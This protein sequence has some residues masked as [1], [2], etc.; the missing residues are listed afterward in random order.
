ML[1]HAELLQRSIPLVKR[2]L[3]RISKFGLLALERCL[4][5][6]KAGFPPLIFSTD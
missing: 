2:V 3:A 1:L 6:K 5:P 4:G